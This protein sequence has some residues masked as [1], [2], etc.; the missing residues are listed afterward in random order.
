M[1]TNLKKPKTAEAFDRYFEG[2]DIADLLDT[3][4]KRVNIDFPAAVLRR[5]DLKAQQ[6][7]LTRQALVK[8]WI[9][10]RLDIVRK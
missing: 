5:L 9:A 10:E 6:L 2:H 8:Y 4:T 1:K 3:D 7:G